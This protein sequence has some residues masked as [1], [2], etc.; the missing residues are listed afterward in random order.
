MSEALPVSSGQKHLVSPP[1]K[2]RDYKKVYVVTQDLQHLM[3]R[4]CANKGL[5]APD[6]DFF[7]LLNNRL[8]RH[9]QKYAFE[10]PVKGHSVKV[11]LVQRERFVHL[12]KPKS[13]PSFWITLDD[14]YVRGA[15]FC[16]RETRI[17]D[18]N[19]FYGDDLGIGAAPGENPLSEQ[20][21]DCVRKYVE[22]G[23]PS[24]VI[25]ADD[26]TYSGG[27]I[28][29]ALS[30]LNQKGIYVTEIRLAF[31]TIG[32]LQEIEKYVIDHDKQCGI[33][34]WPG[35]VVNR[36]ISLMDWVCQR[37]FYLCVPRAGR[38][39]GIVNSRKDPNLPRPEPKALIPEQGFSYLDHYGPI[40]EAGSIRQNERPFS[41]QMVSDSIRLW[42][43]IEK[44]NDNFRMTIG[45]C[46]RYP[47]RLPLEKNMEGDSLVELLEGYEEKDSGR[48]C[49]REREKTLMQLEAEANQVR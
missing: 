3:E 7:T 19:N 44:L 43:E 27:S 17:Y 9:L 48:E 16:I 22:Q 41:N 14:V 12:E 38:T 49:R 31:C 23:E 36:D 33:K 39:A 40:H 42:Q 47:G 45:E 34:Y 20:V 28:K 4:W 32:S 5:R 24:E 15:D 25:L 46:P 2:S 10:K 26:G 29:K 37:D 8:K 35:L 18:P 30:E 11:D 13:D 1:Q 6:S 21:D